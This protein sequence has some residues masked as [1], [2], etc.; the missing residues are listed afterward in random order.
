MNRERESLEPVGYKF[1]PK[2]VYY[3]KNY[4]ISSHITQNDQRS[5]KDSAPMVEVSLNLSQ[6]EAC[7]QYMAGKGLN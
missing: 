7:Y 3:Q 4:P 6:I 1:N 2:I 5:F